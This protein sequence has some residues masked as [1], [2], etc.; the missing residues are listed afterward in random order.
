MPLLNL[1]F[2]VSHKCCNIMKKSPA[3]NFDRDSERVPFIATMT[4]ESNLREAT[5]LKN[6]CNAFDNKSPAS[7]PMSFWTEQDVL[8]YIKENNIPIA[9]VYGDI[10]AVDENKNQYDEQL[11]DGLKLKTTGCHRTGCIFCAFGAHCRDDT[12][13]VD[14]KRTHPKQMRLS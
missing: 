2:K 4:E 13:F 1:P 3:H 5:W 10:V 12:R 6:G 8:Q 14:L 11:I 9:S 7:K